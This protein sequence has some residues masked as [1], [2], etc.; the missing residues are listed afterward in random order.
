MHT[1]PTK[2]FYLDV[3]L[4]DLLYQQLQQQGIV[5]ININIHH[6]Y[7]YRTLMYTLQG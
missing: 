3:Y 2:G 6:Y 5:I 4:C 7:Q 1:K